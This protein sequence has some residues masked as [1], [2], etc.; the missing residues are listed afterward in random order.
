MV[1]CW[2]ERK[3]NKLGLTN[4]YITS[5][6]L[7]YKQPDKMFG[8]H[9]KFGIIGKLSHHIAF[10]VQLED[11]RRSWWWYVCGYGLLFA[12]NTLTS[13]GRLGIFFFLVCLFVLEDI[14]MVLV[15]QRQ[16]T[17]KRLLINHNFFF[18]VLS[19][20]SLLVSHL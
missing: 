5:D 8:R 1:V 7:E 14:W 15:Q 10:T 2:L 4:N 16:R 20:S 6:H 12:Y 19:F 18:V 17:P 9:W 13:F 11:I 3:K